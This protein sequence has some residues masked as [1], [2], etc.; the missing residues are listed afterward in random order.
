[1]TFHPYMDAF[2]TA[3]QYIA[4][5]VKASNNGEGLL[6]LPSNADECWGGENCGVSSA[7]A[8]PQGPLGY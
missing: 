6:I 5:A 8:S 1:V 3:L 7:A 4:R 2:R